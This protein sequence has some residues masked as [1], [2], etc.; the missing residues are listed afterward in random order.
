MH[1][2]TLLIFCDNIRSPVTEIDYQMTHTSN[3]LSSC[4]LTRYIYIQEVI[5]KIV[6]SLSNVN[7]KIGRLLIINLSIGKIHWNY[8][9]ILSSNFNW[10]I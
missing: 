1:Q 3:S 5:Q 2:D 7:W 10:K 6:E 9:V 4:L 8:H